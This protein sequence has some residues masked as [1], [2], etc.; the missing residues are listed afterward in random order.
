VTVPFCHENRG[1]RTPTHELGN[2]LERNTGFKHART[3]RVPK[4]MKQATNLRIRASRFPRFPLCWLVL[5]L[6]LPSESTWKMQNSRAFWPVMWLLLLFLLRNW[7][8]VRE[9]FL[10][11]PGSLVTFAGYKIKA[12]PDLAP[13][14]EAAKPRLADIE[15]RVERIRLKALRQGVVPSLFVGLIDTELGGEDDDIAKPEPSPK[16][17]LWVR[18]VYGEGRQFSESETKSV[19]KEDWLQSFAKYLF[20]RAVHTI[21]RLR[22]LW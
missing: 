21:G 3:T 17:R 10:M 5:F 14:L 15:A 7:I 18:R 16:T 1:C 19:Y 4:V 6:W 22:F 2:N 8:R 9:F 20:Y 11:L 12:D 13:A